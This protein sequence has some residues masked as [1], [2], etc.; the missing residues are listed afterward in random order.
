MW[1]NPSNVWQPTNTHKQH[2]VHKT[3]TPTAEVLAISLL[4]VL[5]KDAASLLEYTTS[6]M[7][8][9][10]WCIEGMTMT[11]LHE[12]YYLKTAFCILNQVRQETS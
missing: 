1:I 8:K 3:D 4:S 5:S 6:L 9:R 7:D 10:I 11:V 2:Q 12:D